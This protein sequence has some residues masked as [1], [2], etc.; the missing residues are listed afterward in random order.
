MNSK[1]EE[2]NGGDEY[3]AFLSKFDK[4]NSVDINVLHQQLGHT[5][6][7]IVKKT[8]KEMGIVLTGKFKICESC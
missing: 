8:S 3:S 4:K 7:L 1:R 5:N 2:H 6:E